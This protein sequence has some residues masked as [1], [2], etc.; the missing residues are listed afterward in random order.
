MS[1]D[2]A[3]GGLGRVCGVLKA[4]GGEHL[5]PRGFGSPPGTADWAEGEENPSGPCPILDPLRGS[6]RELEVG[7]S[8]T[9]SPGYLGSW[10]SS[11]HRDRGEEPLI[12]H[13]WPQ[14]PDPGRGFRNLFTPEL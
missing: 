4:P 10:S 14:I 11:E 7:T 2:A 9:P 6:S 1:A 5:G 3:W 13:T 12:G 8:E